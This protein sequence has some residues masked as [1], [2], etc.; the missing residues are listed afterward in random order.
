MIDNFKKGINNSISKIGNSVY[1]EGIQI[2]SSQAEANSLLQTL[3]QKHQGTII[4]SAEV[5]VYKQKYDRLVNNYNRIFRVVNSARQRL[6]TIDRVVA[7]LN[8]TVNVLSVV[9]T[10]LQLLPAP[11][12]FTL[13]GIIMVLSNRLNSA[14]STISEIKKFLNSVTIV[15]A[16]LISRYNTLLNSL[17]ILNDTLQQILLLLTTKSSEF[18]ADNALED[19]SILE[20]FF[21]NIITNDLGTYKEFKFVLRIEDDPKFNIGDIRRRYAVAIKNNKDI[22]FSDRSYTL[23]PEIL[24]DQL[25]LQIDQ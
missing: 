14:S 24:I 25:K 11:A 17:V 21:N 3:K 19:S 20:G 5:V 22:Y 1:K 8:T 2:N 9:V 10:T 18:K 15:L 12:Q 23:N 7:S 6:K 4:T 16:T 13:L